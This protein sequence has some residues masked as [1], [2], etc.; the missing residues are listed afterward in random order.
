MLDGIPLGVTG[1]T[2]DSVCI[3]GIPDDLAPRFFDAGSARGAISSSSTNGARDTLGSSFAAGTRLESRSDD[4]ADRGS[5]SGSESGSDAA[6]DT[7][8]K[9]C[10]CIVSVP[11]TGPDLG[12]ASESGSDGASDKD[13][14]GASDNDSEASSSPLLTPRSVPSCCAFWARPGNESGRDTSFDSP[15]NSGN[16]SNDNA[17]FESPFSLGRESNCGAST[18]MSSAAS[19]LGLLVPRLLCLGAN[20]FAPRDRAALASGALLLFDESS[21]EST[22][23]APGSS[24][25][26]CGASA[27]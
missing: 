7:V 15:S 3:A 21:P 6:L 12:G 24:G 8:P 22:S 20:L 25:A 18:A 1:G 13:S 16:G 5:E 19:F 4:D 10:S 26:R 17:S 27:C 9:C 23:I 11:A 2:G 14:D